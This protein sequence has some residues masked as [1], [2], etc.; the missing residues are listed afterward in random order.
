MRRTFFAI[1]I[2]AAVLSAAAAS[3]TAIRDSRGLT[4]RR[5][6]AA[7]LTIED[8]KEG[9]ALPT[10]ALTNAAKSVT[11]KLTGYAQLPVWLITKKS[12]KEVFNLLKLHEAG[13]NLFKNPRWKTWVTYVS[14]FDK[15][16][17]EQTMAS[18]L[19]LR[20]GDDVLAEML[21][22]AKMSRKTKSIANKL[23]AAQVN[24]W[25][26]TGQSTDEVFKLLKLHLAGDDLFARTQLST[27]ITFMKRF[28]KDF[29]DES[30]TLLSTLS[31]HYKDGDL[32]R[33]AHK[34]LLIDSSKKMANDFQILQ[35]GK[36]ASEEKTPSAVAHLLVSSR[37]VPGSATSQRTTQLEKEIVENY[38][39]FNAAYTSSLP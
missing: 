8:D 5:L 28:N 4:R 14:K 38:K 29:A 32:A 36:W 15:T 16:N 31:K 35:F 17:P 34:G 1:L 22:A 26:A 7:A 6:R 11:S 10:S 27:W 24:N 37:T 33:I 20:Y 2:L 21:A 19:T 13:S 12:P 25:M 3:T 39:R 23:E 9:R 18:V 30:T